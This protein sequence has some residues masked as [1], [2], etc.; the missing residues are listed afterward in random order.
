LLGDVEG[1]YPGWQQTP[2][3]LGDRDLKFFDTVLGAIREKYPVDDRR[4]Y[5][6]GFSNGGFFT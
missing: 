5:A 4:I 1:K 3:Q 6:T 2:G